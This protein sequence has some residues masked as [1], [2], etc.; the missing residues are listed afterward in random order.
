MNDVFVFVR[1]H[2]KHIIKMFSHNAVW[3]LSTEST[4]RDLKYIIT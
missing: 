4:V 3:L 2:D 1:L